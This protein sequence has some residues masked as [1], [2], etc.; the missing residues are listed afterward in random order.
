MKFQV[1]IGILLTL[2]RKRRASARELAEK[3]GVSTRSIY[4]YVDELSIAG[5]PVE[6]YRGSRGGIYI[7]DAFKL[8][9]GFL[10]KNEYARAIDAM[11]A[12]NAQLDDP[13]LKSAI[14]KLSSEL[15]HEK[16]DGALSGNIL[17]DSGTWGDERRFSDKLALAERA[18]AEREELEIDYT[19]R[20]GEQTRRKILPHLLVYKQNVWY[21]Y[22]FCRTRNAFRLFKLGRM[23]S[24]LKTGETFERIPFAREDIP[25]NFWTNADESIDARFEITSEALPYA[26]EWFGVENVYK[27]DG[28]LYADVTLPNDESLLGKI[29]SIGSGFRVLSPLSLAERVKKEAEKLVSAYRS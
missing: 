26:E 14:E 7:S 15:K 25:L 27:K 10:T 16:F 5:I 3:Y 2:L 23:R 20:G 24:I 1:M 28:G 4:R 22:A 17:V 18:I 11:L 29:L 21:L 13:D 8:P 19:D 12:M 9:R 6:V